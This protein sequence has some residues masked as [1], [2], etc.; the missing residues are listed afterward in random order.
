ML[1]RSNRHEGKESIIYQYNSIMGLV[2]IGSLWGAR[3]FITGIP[4]FAWGI[5]YFIVINSMY[6]EDLM[7]LVESPYVILSIPCLSNNE[8][9]KLVSLFI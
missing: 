3:I 8:S 4:V 2:N 9:S 1:H 7:T 6:I 5:S